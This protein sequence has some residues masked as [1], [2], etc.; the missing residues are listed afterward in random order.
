[1]SYSIGTR[2]RALCADGKTR[3]ALILNHPD[4]FFSVPARVKVQGKTVTG[5]VYL[6]GSS[7]EKELRFSASAWMKN[8]HLLQW[9]GK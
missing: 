7:D 8:A 6:H 5:F 3:S 1:M 2:H 4:T 9:G